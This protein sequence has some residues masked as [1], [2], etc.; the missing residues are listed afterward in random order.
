MNINLKSLGFIMVNPIVFNE[1]DRKDILEFARKIHKEHGYV[2]DC[3]IRS[4]AGG[5]F[6]KRIRAFVP[7]SEKD[8]LLGRAQVLREIHR[9][10]MK[11]SGVK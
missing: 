6:P 9:D 10:K 3:G 7:E 4:G 8:R 2:T 11:R 1:S 5:K